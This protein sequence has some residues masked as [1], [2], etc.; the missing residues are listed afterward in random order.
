MREIDIS[1]LFHFLTHVPNAITSLR[2]EG[3]SHIKNEQIRV[4]FEAIRTN[5]T[6]QSL[7]L[8]HANFDSKGVKYLCDA[9]LVNTAL[10]E[11]DIPSV[12]VGDEGAR[13]IARFL[14]FNTTLRI[15][16]LSQNN[17]SARA[18]EE[19]GCEAICEVLAEKNTS[20]LC[21]DLTGNFTNYKCFEL[22]SKSKNLVFISLEPWNWDSVTHRNIMAWKGKI[23]WSC[24][25]NYLCR[26][27]VL[28]G[29]CEIL[30]LEMVFYVL[31]FVVPKGEMRE[32]E[33]K[34]VTQFSCDIECLGKDKVMFLEA[35]FGKAMR[36]IVDYRNKVRGR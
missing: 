14:A 9:L 20:L 18:L 28:G 21:L 6:L 2:L 34:R 36:Y 25:L 24:V 10:T 8:P 17:Y 27:M 31:G 23:E 11:L 1:H 12:N 5:S 4:I 22:I 15:L 26:V 19:R 3:F 7:S 32:D 35:V 33:M 30:P 13:H 29:V 16:N